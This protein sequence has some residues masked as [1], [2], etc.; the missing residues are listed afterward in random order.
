MFAKSEDLRRSL[1]KLDQ[2][3]HVLRTSAVGDVIDLD[4][5]NLLECSRRSI[6]NM[7][8]ARQR[9][10]SNPIVHLQAWRDGNLAA[11]PII[12]D[13]SAPSPET[14]HPQP[15]RPRLHSVS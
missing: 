3:L 2:T 10:N 4:E 1:S 15:G 6:V 9:Q 14:M 5:I 13:R 7:L 12:T 8:D 11:L